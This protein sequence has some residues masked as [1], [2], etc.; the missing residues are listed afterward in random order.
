M[1][2]LINE[3]DNPA[4][5]PRHL[6]SVEHLKR[7]KVEG[8][9]IGEAIYSSLVDKCFNTQPNLKQEKRTIKTMARD[10]YRIWKSALL[11]LKKEKFDRVYI[12]N[13]RFSTTRAW[14][15]ACQKEGV[16]FSTH[17]RSM[18]L[19]KM[20]LVNGALPQDPTTYKYRI[21]EFLDRTKGDAAVYEE[22][23]EFFEERAENKNSAWRV[24]T[25]RQE[26]G[27][28]PIGWDPKR[29][30]LAFFASTEREFVGV[31]QFTPRGIYE[32]QIEALRDLVPKAAAADESLQFYLRIHPNSWREKHRWWEEA[33]IADLPS[34]RVIP[35]ES[36]V[37]TYS[38]MAAVEKTMCFRSSMG[39]ESTYWGKPSIVL[40]W[41]FYA[42][43][44]AVYEPS[45]RQEAL[46]FVLEKLRPKPRENAVKFGSFMRC[47]GVSLKH[48]TP[49]EDLGQLKFKGERLRASEEVT[50][51]ARASF[52][53]PTVG[54]A[55]TLLRN[56]ADSIKFRLL[57]AKKTGW[58]AST[59]RIPTLA[60]R[61]HK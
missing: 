20:F 39:I 10:S 21:E 60:V 33:G 34:L 38:L 46:E 24:F 48:A 25:N 12:F 23:V 52:N 16:P 22:G 4:I 29:R 35:P 7:I 56:V 57:L 40:T 53:R 11:L 18:K 1:L 14:V 17:E 31:K 58:L 59:P 9:D 50:N 26:K 37:S 42:G 3:I 61:H 54:R 51:W 8:F 32:S 27:E 43:I 41:A 47:G 5:I 49:V 44:D 30:N 36:S 13:G 19:G 2:P 15:R 55:L 6:E 28:M 45:T